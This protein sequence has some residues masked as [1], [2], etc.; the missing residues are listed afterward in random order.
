MCG[1]SYVLVFEYVRCV[2]VRYKEICMCV[3]IRYDKMYIG[4]QL[5]NRLVSPIIMKLEITC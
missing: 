3:Y 4:L 1:C 2:Y 5:E